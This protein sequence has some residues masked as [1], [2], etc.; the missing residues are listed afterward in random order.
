MAYAILPALMLCM[1]RFYSPDDFQNTS[2][3]LLMICICSSSDFYP[4]S[5]NS[6]IIYNTTIYYS[7]NLL[8]SFIY[9]LLY[10]FT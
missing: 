5:C 6:K 3:V 4:Q 8:Y 9:N 10:H 1:Y 7:K 2:P